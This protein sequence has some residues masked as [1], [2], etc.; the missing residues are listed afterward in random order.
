M[1]TAPVTVMLPEVVSL[2]PAVVTCS[3]PP[4]FTVTV[5]ATAV[6]VSI[7][8]GD[9]V[10]IVTLSAATGTLWPPA[11]PQAVAQ[12]AVEL[13]LPPAATEKRFA[14]RAALARDNASAA[15]NKHFEI[16]LRGCN[17]MIKLAKMTVL[18]G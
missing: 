10:Q 14:A 6:A 11:L 15:P 5:A 2:F 9:P 13:Q 17:F 18:P 3:V 4:V 12:V 1:L 16:L 7:V 8:T